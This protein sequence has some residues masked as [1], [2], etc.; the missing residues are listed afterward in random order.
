[1][2]RIS[3]SGSS[4]FHNPSNLGINSPHIRLKD[5]SVLDQYVA[6]SRLSRQ[7]EVRLPRLSICSTF[8]GDWNVGSVWRE[9]STHRYPVYTPNRSFDLMQDLLLSENCG[10][11]LV[12]VGILRNGSPLYMLRSDLSQLN[13]EGGSRELR[14]DFPNGIRVR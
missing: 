11:T 4:Q 6:P 2:L 8:P 5:L 14:F 7:P 9:G 1:M 12:R 13:A 3:T 10:I